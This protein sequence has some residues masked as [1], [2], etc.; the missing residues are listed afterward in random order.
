MA[1]HNSFASR[2]IV[3]QLTAWLPKDNEEINT[4]VKSLH[5][6]LDAATITDP[7]LHLGDGRWGQDPYHRQSP[8]GD[9]A[10]SISPP[11]ERDQGQGEEDLRDVIHNRDASDRIENCHQE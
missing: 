6:V 8:C 5:A 10:S 2:V 3:N 7:T 1:A 11:G 9:S 4:Q